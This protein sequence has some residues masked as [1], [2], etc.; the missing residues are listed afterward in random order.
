MLLFTFF[1][2][3][4]VVSRDSN[5]HSLASSLFLLIT[6][7]SGILAEIRWSVCMSKSHRRLC[8][9]VSRT[10]AG[11][12]IYHLF[13]GANFNFWHISQWITF[14]TQSYLV[15]N[16]FCANLLHSL[17][18]RLMVSTLSP[19]NLNLLFCC[20]LSILA[21]I[22]LVLIALFC[23]AITRESVSLLKRAFLSHV[24]V[25]SC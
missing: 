15:L 5:A 19:H 7:R 16:S 11:L 8:M 25:F 20:V 4:S 9:S 6:I 24:H 1:R 14:P 12:C 10:D 21:L 17:I 3:Y 22:W 18:M 13:V 23:A 2:F